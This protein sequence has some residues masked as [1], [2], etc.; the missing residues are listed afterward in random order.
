MICFTI[1]VCCWTN[2]LEQLFHHCQKQRPT[3]P[4]ENP[5]APPEVVEVVSG[6]MVSIPEGIGVHSEKMTQYDPLTKNALLPY[7][8]SK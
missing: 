2:Y 1:W 4:L 6:G 5:E 8:S 3:V 7:P